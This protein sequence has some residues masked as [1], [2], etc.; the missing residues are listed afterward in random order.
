ML[1]AEVEWK[2]MKPALAPVTATRLSEKRYLKN[3]SRSVPPV[4]PSGRKRP[5]I[6]VTLAQTSQ[7]ADQTRTKVQRQG[8]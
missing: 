3:P 1:P 5:C 4:P 2:S 7:L 8:P 6:L